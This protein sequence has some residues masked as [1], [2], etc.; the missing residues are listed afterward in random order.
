MFDDVSIHSTY[1][2]RYLSDTANNVRYDG[3]LPIVPK[4]TSPDAKIWSYYAV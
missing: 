2:L 1:E 3:S 4:A